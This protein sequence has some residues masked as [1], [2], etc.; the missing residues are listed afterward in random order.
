[1]FFF[2]SQI[3]FLHTSILSLERKPPTTGTTIDIFLKDFRHFS[4]DFKTP[5]ECADTLESLENLSHPSGCGQKH[6]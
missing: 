4:I 1:M 6:M 3:Q 2:A 5:E